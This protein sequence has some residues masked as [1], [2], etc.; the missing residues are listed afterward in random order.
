MVKKKVSKTF[1]LGRD[2][3]NGQFISVKAARKRK[4]TATVEKIPKAGYGD[5]K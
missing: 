4:S 1:L 2:A 5:T 3:R